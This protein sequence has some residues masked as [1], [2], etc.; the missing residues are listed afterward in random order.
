MEI[1]FKSWRSKLVN[2]TSVWY[3]FVTNN[4]CLIGAGLIQPSISTTARSL[5]LTDVTGSQ[6]RSTSDIFQVSFLGEGY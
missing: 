5:A 1:N 2:V 4:T 6:V 3:R